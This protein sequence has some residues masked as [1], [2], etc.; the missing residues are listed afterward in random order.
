[1]SL[2]IE[3]KFLVKNNDYK[4]IASK[5]TKII[6]GYLSID[7]ARTVRVRIK[8]QHAYI[9]IKGKSNISG[10]SRYEWEKPI[11]MDEANQLL[12]LCLP[13]II[14]KI[15]YEIVSGHHLIEV[16]EFFGKNEG[17]TIAEIELSDENETIL[18]PSWIGAE[19]TGD[20]RYYNAQMI[21]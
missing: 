10:T 19:V 18:L 20:P 8:G 4:A 15:R 11:S 2:E 14:D 12:E 3:R 1:M 21:G 5:S 9:T 7:P 13:G 16:D 17:L 6:Q